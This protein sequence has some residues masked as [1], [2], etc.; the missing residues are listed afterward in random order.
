MSRMRTGSPSCRIPPLQWLYARMLPQ[1]RD[2]RPQMTH[3]LGRAESGA[4]GTGAPRART[5]SC[6]ASTFAA[7]AVAQPPTVQ[8]SSR[9]APTS[10]GSVAGHQWPLLGNITSVALVRSARRSPKFGRDVGVVG[11][12]EDDARTR[13]QLLVDVVVPLGEPGRGRAVELQDAVL[14]RGV[15][16]RGHRG[17]LLRAADLFGERVDE[18]VARSSPP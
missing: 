11:T 9:R 8:S 3:T 7:S 18:R 1:H 17:R 6:R 5:P 12:P 2:M 15:D 16:V 13:R 10:A 4:R 14:H